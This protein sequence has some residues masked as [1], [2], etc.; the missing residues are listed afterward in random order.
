MGNMGKPFVT[1]LCVVS[2]LVYSAS[3]AAS[4]WCSF[5]SHSGHRLSNRETVMV[6]RWYDKLQS[7]CYMHPSA[8]FTRSP[9]VVSAWP[10]AC[11]R[12]RRATRDGRTSG[13][14]LTSISWASLS[15]VSESGAIC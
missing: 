14:V 9:V 11:G 7:A 8:T 5:M 3:Y 4:P 15:S 13:V 12:I 10:A 2:P 1:H 6:W